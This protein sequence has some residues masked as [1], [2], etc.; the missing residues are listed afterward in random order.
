[1]P[2]RERTPSIS[3]EAAAAASQST[4]ERPGPDTEQAR[5]QAPSEEGPERG[6]SELS[7]LVDRLYEPSTAIGQMGLSQQAEPALAQGE[8]E[9]L[10]Q[11]E[12]E[13]RGQH[14]AFWRNVVAVAIILVLLLL[15]GIG[16][17]YWDAYH[18]EYVEYY[19][20]VIKRWGLPAGVGRLTDEQF[21]RRNSTLMFIKRGRQGAVHE[22]RQ[23]NSRG[24]YPPTFA[25]IGLHPLSAVNPLERK[26]YQGRSSE[27][28]ETSRVRFERDASNKI[29][30]QSAYNRAG[31]RLYTLH[32]DNAEPNFAVYKEGAFPVAVRES[33]ITHIEFVRLEDGPEAGLDKELRFFGQGKTPQP[34]HDGANGYRYVLDH[35]GLAVEGT[36]LGS[37]GQ[38]TVTRNGIAKWSST[39][40]ALGQIIQEAFFGHDSQPILNDFGAA[41]TK[42]S[43]D[44][45]GN[46]TEIAFL[47]AEGQLVTVSGSERLAA[48]FATMSGAISSRPLSLIRTIDW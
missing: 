24:V 46:I 14:T 33:G 23:V 15:A 7:V 39:Y 32:Y 44:G 12:R 41:G 10:A 22:I 17:W 36:P 38:P 8:Q 31:R 6:P 40:N 1:M 25:Q 42:I 34:N 26:D 29:L 3:M 37:D 18:R 16:G 20:N 43:Y 30:T 27:W 21:R 47:G 9:S 35:R 45:H 28:L 13:L 4:S 2:P 19:A 5:S 11:P 48:G